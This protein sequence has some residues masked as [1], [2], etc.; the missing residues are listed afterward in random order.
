VAHGGLGGIVPEALAHWVTGHG[1]ESQ[2]RDQLR[3]RCRQHHAHLGA[4]LAEAADDVGRLV[5]GNAAGDAQ[6]Y[7]FAIAR[8]GLGHKLGDGRG[9]VAGGLVLR[10]QPEGDALLVGRAVGAVRHPVGRGGGRFLGRQARAVHGREHRHAAVVEGDRR[11]LH[12]RIGRVN[13]L[14]RFRG[15]TGHEHQGNA[16]ACKALGPA[17]AGRGRNPRARHHR[18]NSHA[19]KS[20]LHV[21]ASEANLTYSKHI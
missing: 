3:G 7:L 11:L 1:L 17:G 20:R 12:P 8:L 13:G 16:R 4:K 2:R 10:L 18:L 6:Q 15:R 5:G 19:P 21:A 9:L 14:G